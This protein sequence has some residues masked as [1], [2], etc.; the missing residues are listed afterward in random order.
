MAANKRQRLSV[1]ADAGRE[2]GDYNQQ[3]P[4]LY[5]HSLHCADAASP[6]HARKGPQLRA[7]KVLTSRHDQQCPAGVALHHSSGAVHTLQPSQES[8]PL[9][10]GAQLASSQL[11]RKG[12]GADSSDSED[13]LEASRGNRRLSNGRTGA[14]VDSDE[15]QEATEPVDAAAQLA[16]E[17]LDPLPEQPAEQRSSRR[18]SIGKPSRLDIRARMQQNQQKL[19]KVLSLHAYMRHEM[20]DEFVS[21]T[22]QDPAHPSGASARQPACT[23]HCSSATEGCHKRRQCT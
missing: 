10:S 22:H 11:H 12:L 16:E 9:Q 17:G 5:M 13:M 7:A 23:C 4:G 18:T 20:T 3:G 6:S 15:L 8:H 19:R 21:I 2:S 14:Q 1:S